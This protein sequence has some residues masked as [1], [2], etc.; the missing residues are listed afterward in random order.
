MPKI[1]SRS[2]HH[3]WRTSLHHHQKITRLYFQ[4][5]M[6]TKNHIGGIIEHTT[7]SSRRVLYPVPC[8]PLKGNWRFGGTYRIDL[9]CRISRVKKQCESRWQAEVSGPY[10]H[11]KRR[12]TFNVL[13]CVISITTVVR[14]SNP[15]QQF[16][17]LRLST[18]GM[19]HPRTCFGQT[20]CLPSVVYQPVSFLQCH[21]S[22]VREAMLDRI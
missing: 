9:Q 22:T 16:S 19:T 11:P 6:G 10:F 5:K 8:S 2:S 12:L 20:I 13:S 14:T 4:P 15:T 1:S 18:Q 3:Q 21:S 7:I 17:Y